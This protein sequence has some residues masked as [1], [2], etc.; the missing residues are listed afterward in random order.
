MKEIV[1]TE[2]TTAA[3]S[4]MWIAKQC[5]PG[6]AVHANKMEHRRNNPT[7]EYIFWANAVINA[8]LEEI[9]R[10]IV[11]RNCLD[12]EKILVTIGDC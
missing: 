1:V 8:I 3:S 4:C 6:H 5:D 10:A 9:G 7:A 11:F 12:W 2:M